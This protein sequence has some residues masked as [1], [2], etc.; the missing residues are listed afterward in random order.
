MHVT[1]MIC[2]LLTLFIRVFKPDAGS[3]VFQFLCELYMFLGFFFH[4]YNDIYKG[5]INKSYLQHLP[6]ILKDLSAAPR[7]PLVTFNEAPLATRKEW[8]YST[9]DS[10]SVGVTARHTQ[11]PTAKHLVFLVDG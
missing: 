9:F 11:Q 5:F 7:C 3:V 6:W 2:L 10:N 8:P 4:I 1:D